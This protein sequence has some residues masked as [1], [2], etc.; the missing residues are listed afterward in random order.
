METAETVAIQ[1]LAK[2]SIFVIT[3]LWQLTP[4]GSL[5]ASLS[6]GQYGVLPFAVGVISGPVNGSYQGFR[7]LQCFMRKINGNGPHRGPEKPFLS[8]STVPVTFTDLEQRPSERTSPLTHLT[9][10]LYRGI[11]KLKGRW[12]KKKTQSISKDSVIV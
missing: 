3:A 7:T 2:A 9:Q 12:Q 4:K 6:V 11:K 1:R 10:H 8:S 5:N